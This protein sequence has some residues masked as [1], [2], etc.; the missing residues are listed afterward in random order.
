M[1]SP[2]QRVFEIIQETFGKYQGVFGKNEDI[3]RYLGT[4]S[5][6]GVEL[7]QSGFELNSTYENEPIT[8]AAT[9]FL[10]DAVLSSNSKNDTLTFI[11][12]MAG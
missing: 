2:P 6:R 5:V 3:L 1:P 10:P 11:P 4:G 12:T 8:F 9:E 7:I